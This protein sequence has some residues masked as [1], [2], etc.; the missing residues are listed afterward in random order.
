MVE[1]GIVD[2]S[3]FMRMIL[4]KALASGRGVSVSWEAGGYEEALKLAAE[5]P[6]VFVLLNLKSQ[7]ID[8]L[9][10]L[11]GILGKNPG[12][13][14]AVLSDSSE[15]GASD[16]A[17]ALKLGAV[18][19]VQA[20]SGTSGNEMEDL[21]KNLLGMLG[22]LGD[23]GGQAASETPMRGMP[24]K[25]VV[26]CASTGG[27][28]EIRQVLSMLGKGLPANLLI[29]LQKHSKFTK[30]LAEDLPVKLKAEARI[31][32][33]IA[34]DGTELADGEA[35]LVLGDSDFEVT[36]RGN[37]LALACRPGTGLGGASFDVLMESVASACGENSIGVLLSGG[38]QDGVAGLAAIR[39]Q[40]GKSIVQDPAMRCTSPQMARNAIKSG[41]A[42]YVVPIDR[43]ASKIEELVRGDADG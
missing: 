11:S 20:P 19:M 42:D 13:R 31:P 15:K 34:E 6:D 30:I 7:G 10:L 36:G 18:G 22:E 21:K 40:G 27:T 8:G 39:G 3:K 29:V 25:V 17:E 32:V 1:V 38:G 35:V 24:S 43:I 37:G 33:R 14:V 9:G 16:S 23:G 26:I 41:N 5:S 12:A 28:Q 4:R 2:S